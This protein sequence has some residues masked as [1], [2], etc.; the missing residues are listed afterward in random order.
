MKNRAEGP[1][2]SSLVS[3]ALSDTNSLRYTHT[4]THTKVTKIDVNERLEFTRSVCMGV[5]V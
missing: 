3:K 5:C 1:F 2:I 4:H